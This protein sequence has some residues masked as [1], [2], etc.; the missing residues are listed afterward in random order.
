MRSD[1][2]R[3]KRNGHLIPT[4][5]D[6]FAAMAATLGQ[7]TAP[8]LSQRQIAWMGRLD[9][10]QDMMNALPQVATDG[11]LQYRFNVDALMREHRAMLEAGPGYSIV[12][13]VDPDT[14]STAGASGKVA[15]GSVNSST[16]SSTVR[17]PAAGQAT[18]SNFLQPDILPVQKE[19]WSMHKE[20][21]ESAAEDQKNQL[22]AAIAKVRNR[23]VNVDLSTP[24]DIYEFIRHESP[25]GA[26]L[27]E[28][29]DQFA[30]EERLQFFMLMHAS[31]TDDV[32]REASRVSGM[33]IAVR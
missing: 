7:R 12:P 21:D 33:P 28:A 16:D 1:E 8:K 22:M 5:A 20:K 6:P 2:A 10:I 23:T 26:E 13:D 14:D 11:S 4:T 15:L 18:A 9:D 3:S 27:L 29:G 24:E 25:Y 17:T 30:G 32:L 19:W 31:G